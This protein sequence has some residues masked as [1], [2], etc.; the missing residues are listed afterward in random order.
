MKNNGFTL[1]ELLVVTGIFVAIST[2]IAGILVST[3]R[4]SEQTT[5]NTGATQ[6]AN[7]ALSASTDLIKRGENILEVGGNPNACVPSQSGD[8]LKIELIDGGITTISCIAS[9]GTD[10]DTIASSS[11]YGTVP[12]NDPKIVKV[13]NCSFTCY[14]PNIVTPPRVEVQFDATPA[15]DPA[16]PATTYKTQINIRNYSY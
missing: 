4:S 2:I 14:Q 11:A 9:N 3:L 15:N 16:R 13:N 1:V 8:S 10:I 7:Y 12:Y 6:S 5:F